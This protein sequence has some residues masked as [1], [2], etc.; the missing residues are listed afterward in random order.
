MQ[1]NRD[2]KPMETSLGED[3]QFLSHIGSMSQ[4]FKHVTVKYKCS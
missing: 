3:L 1:T 2:S 4:T